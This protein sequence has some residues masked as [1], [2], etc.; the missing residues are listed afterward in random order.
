[1]IR[2]RQPIVVVLGHVDSGKTSLLDKIRKTAVQARE[3]GGITQHIGASILP[4]ETLMEICGPLLSKVGGDIKVPGILVIDTP[5]HEVFSN[6]RIRGGSAADFSIIVTDVMKGVEAQTVESLEILRQRR[7]PFVLAL[8]KIDM[9]SGWKTGPNSFVTESLKRQSPSVIEILD[10]QL[11]TVVG[12]LSRLGFRSELYSRVKSFTKEVAI[13]PVSAKTGEGVPELL[14]IIVGLTQ[15][16]M[17][18][19]LTYELGAPSGIILEV[20][21]EVGLGVSADVILIDGVLKVGDMLAMMKKE[22]ASPV[23]VRAILMPKPLD[24]MR[25]PTDKFSHV[26]GVYAAAGV[27]LVSPELDGVLPGSRFLGFDD[28]SKFDSIKSQIEEEV[29]GLLFSKDE[30]GLV[31]KADALG[32]L[33]AIVDSLKKNNIPI[34]LA[35]IGPLSRRDV[36]E[37]TTVAEKDPFLGVI[38]Y[39][40]VKAYPDAEELMIAKKVKAFNDPVIFNIIEGYLHWVES[41]RQ[42][43]ESMEFGSLVLPCKVQAM[44]GF[45]FRRSNPAIFGVEVLGGRLKQKFRMMKS[46]GEVVGTINGVQDK[47]KSIDIAYKGNQVAVS[48]KEAVIGRSFNEGDILYSSPSYNNF[49]VL[50]EKY[51]ERLDEGEKKIFEEILKI[52]KAKDP[53]FI[54][55]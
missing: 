18:S 54:F 44:K 28:M 23:K 40:H 13:V 6:L 31:I 35:D 3:S 32:S 17:M 39:F 1:M 37:A 27:K 25:D 51:F 48:I 50:K 26:N 12:S 30:L 47:G 4:R 7:V 41:E 24:E 34:R 38:L 10:R 19:N 9:I 11:Y 2:Y 14:S 15:Q 36:I 43:I 29:K 33:E 52:K 42:R 45:V 46:D 21:E 20:K 49:K 22:G 16:F 55:L 8:N 5:G 53:S